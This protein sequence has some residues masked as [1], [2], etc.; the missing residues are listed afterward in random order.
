[1]G[2][3]TM[4]YVYTGSYNGIKSNRGVK[5]LY[6]S[7]CIRYY[8]ASP[9]PTMRQEMMAPDMMADQMNQMM[10]VMKQHVMTTNEIK[11][12][13]DMINERCKRMEDQMK[14]MKQMN[15]K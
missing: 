5:T 1:M 12:T 13:V 15:E 2:I 4:T 9:M 6:Y 10:D 8:Y 7:P 3:F 14:Q 11:R